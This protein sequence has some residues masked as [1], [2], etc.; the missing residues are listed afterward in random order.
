MF[1]RSSVVKKA[2]KTYRYWKL[3][4]NV[5]TDAGPR[6]Q[7]V[8][9]LGDLSKVTAAEWQALAGLSQPVRLRRTLPD[10]RGS[11][12]RSPPALRPARRLPYRDQTARFRFGGREA[13]FLAAPA[14]PPLW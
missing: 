3:V 14:P 5:R 7:V 13:R 4:E 9:H 10:G 11:D 2:G 8:A 6:Q 1:L 12:R